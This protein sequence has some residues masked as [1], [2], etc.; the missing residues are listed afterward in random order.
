MS[1]MD[2]MGYD[3]IDGAALKRER[4]AESEKVLDQFWRLIATM[5]QEPVKTHSHAQARGNPPEQDADQQRSPTEPKERGHRSDMKKRHEDG[6]IPLNTFRSFLSH[7]LVA[8]ENS[9]AF[10]LSKPTPRHLVTVFSCGLKN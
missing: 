3:P 7:C 8:H 2:A 4:A 9:W 6:G 5:S 1:V 10:L